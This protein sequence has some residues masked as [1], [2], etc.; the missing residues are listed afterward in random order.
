[1]CSNI[2]VSKNGTNFCILFYLMS[3]ADR[4]V[5]SGTMSDLLILFYSLL[6]CFFVELRSGNGGVRDVL[7]WQ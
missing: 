4:I 2:S 7:R 5:D 1:M 3:G 6:F